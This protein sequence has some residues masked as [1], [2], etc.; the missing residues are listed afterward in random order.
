V[1]EKIFAFAFL[2]FGPAGRVS[3][4]IY[5]GPNFQGF[6]PEVVALSHKG[7]SIKGLLLVGSHR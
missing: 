1:F 3:I 6:A 2:D 5:K 4:E 7:R